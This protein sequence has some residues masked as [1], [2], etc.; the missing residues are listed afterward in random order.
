MKVLNEIHCFCDP[1]RG[2]V[3]KVQSYLFVQSSRASVPY[4]CLEVEV[5]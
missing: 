3:L 1:C 5:G 2:F 4:A